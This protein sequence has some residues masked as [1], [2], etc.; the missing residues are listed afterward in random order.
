MIGSCVIYSY[1]FSF[2]CW[3][4]FFYTQ[5]LLSSFFRIYFQCVSIVS[6]SIFLFV[7]M[8]SSRP[9]KCVVF[10]SNYLKS[11]IIFCN[12]PVKCLRL[13]SIESI[14]GKSGIS[15]K[16]SGIPKEK[17]GISPKKSNTNRKSGISTEKGF[18]NHLEIST[19]ILR[20]HLEKTSK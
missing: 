20:N 6:S 16:K 8:S 18:R 19:I 17:A 5:R 10:I 11:A 9:G 1:F 15:P 13:I 14:N 7:I 12:T 3:K 4:L 2:I